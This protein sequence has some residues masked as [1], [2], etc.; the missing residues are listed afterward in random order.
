M[1]SIRS[2]TAALVAG[3][4]LVLLLLGGGA[5]LVVI[6]AALTAQFD[7]AL[8]AR[9]EALRSLTRF[10]GTKVEMDFAGEA[11][12]RFVRSGPRASGAEGS[13]FFVAWVQSEGAWRVLERSESLGNVEWPGEP[14]RDAA[15]GGR[16]LDLPGG[17]LGRGVVV[18]FIAIAEHDEE[19]ERAVEGVV[20]P[21]AA[22]AAGAAQTPPRIRLLVA[23]SRGP[24]DRTLAIV[25][26][27]I[28]GVGVTL[29]LASVGL[30]R[31][32]VGRGLMPLSDLSRKVQALGPESLSTRLES[33]ELPNE[34]RP[35]ADQLSALLARLDE[36]FNR[37]KRFSAAASHELRTPIAEL[38][39]LLEVAR[40]RPRTNEEWHDTSGRA[41]G[42]LDRTQSLCE[43]LLRLSRA[44][45]ADALS[46]SQGRAEVNPILAEQADRIL[47]VHGG[48]VRR[49]RVES[50][51]DV[52]AR[53][54]A[55]SLASIIGNLFDNALRHG[56]ATPD[57]PVIVRAR[58]GTGFVRIEVRNSA[59]AL[60]GDD[61]AHLFEP[62]WRK[63][64]S[65][66]DRHGFGLG[67]AVARTLARAGGGDI[68]ARLDEP[69]VLVVELTLPAAS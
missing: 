62:F 57:D 63:D 19:G 36:A 27:S 25:G 10:D 16:D 46:D 33:R 6:R 68:T 54:D 30:V 13:E 35:I 65:R 24:L 48:D 55:T 28:G 34:L 11:M 12:P 51:E 17:T 31:W 42:V 61:R 52:V 41:L 39:M 64:A 47:S 53:I 20:A 50:G 67:L 32:G 9:A 66:Q 8:A 49:L 1:M 26:W 44:G 69:D 58:S 15:P 3:S 56:D 43:T 23:L 5:L 60:T 37:E 29:A 21:K 59:P 7:D 18:E 4:I 40:S 45:T 2:R 22:T 38:R 14:L